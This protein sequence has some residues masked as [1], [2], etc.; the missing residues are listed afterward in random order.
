MFACPQYCFDSIVLN[1]YSLES[2]PMSICRIGEERAPSSAAIALKV[3]GLRLALL[4]TIF[5]WFLICTAF[6]LL[7]FRFARSR[8]VY[9]SLFVLVVE[10]RL[11]DL[12]PYYCSLCAVIFDRL[13]VVLSWECPDNETFLFDWYSCLLALLWLTFCPW[14]TCFVSVKLAAKCA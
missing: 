6:L 8:E 3:S 1:S 5:F 4:R 9:A 12:V 13:D 7:K 14:E 11:A 10:M 2:S